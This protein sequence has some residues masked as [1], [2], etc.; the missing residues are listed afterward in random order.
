MCSGNKDKVCGSQ[1]NVSLVYSNQCSTKIDIISCLRFSTKIHITTDEKLWRGWV[2]NLLGTRDEDERRDKIWR[3]EIRDDFWAIFSSLDYISWGNDFR[4]LNDYNLEVMSHSIKL[5]FFRDEINIV[6][7]SRLGWSVDA[8]WVKHWSEE[9]KNG[10][11]IR[12]T[13]FV[14]SRSG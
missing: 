13:H 3:D 9:A 10:Q 6:P 4:I 14:R 12:S 11:L 8:D 7:S 2:K 5:D 1:D